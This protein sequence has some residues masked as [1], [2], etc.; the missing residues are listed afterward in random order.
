[1]SMSI[2][3]MVPQHHTAGSRLFELNAQTH[4]LKLPPEI[5]TRIFELALT[6]PKPVIFD[7][8]YHPKPRKP[9][10]PQVCQQIRSDAR[11]LSFHLKSFQIM[12]TFGD[13]TKLRSWLASMADDELRNIQDINFEFSRF[14]RTKKR[15]ALAMTPSD[16]KYDTFTRPFATSVF[17]QPTDTAMTG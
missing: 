11:L 16:A 17:E 3:A 12:I 4:L 10:L 14:L 1:M 15:Y 13:N 7:L 9:A 8:G 6:S 5:R 2:S